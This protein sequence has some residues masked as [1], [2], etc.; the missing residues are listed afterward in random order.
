MDAA[1]L[2]DA[3]PNQAN[4]SSDSDSHDFDDDWQ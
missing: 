4:E 1:D 2:A 3:G